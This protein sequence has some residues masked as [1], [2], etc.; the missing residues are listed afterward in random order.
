MCCK[1]HQTCCAEGTVCDPDGPGCLAPR[2]DLRSSRA[3][4][5]ERDGALFEA[6]LRMEM[7]ENSRRPSGVAEH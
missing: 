1:D 2:T 3:S 7:A 5:Y 6:G 4:T